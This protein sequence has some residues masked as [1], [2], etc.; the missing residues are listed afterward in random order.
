M[1]E[2][3]DTW[4]QS[5]GEKLEE[6]TGQERHKRESA[7]VC[8]RVL[9]L[10]TPFEGKKQRFADRQHCSRMQSLEQISQRTRTKDKR[11]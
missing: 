4:Q 11:K 9:L 7:C 2:C 8:M 5:R 3:Y 6:K 1:S 10:V